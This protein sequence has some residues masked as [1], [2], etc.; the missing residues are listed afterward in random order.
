[1]INIWIFVFFILISTIGTFFLMKYLYMRNIENVTKTIR[2][3]VHRDNTLLNFQKDIECLLFLI[4]FKMNNSNKYIVD[5]MNITHE[6]AY[7]NEDLQNKLVEQI[8][9]D[10]V[11][12]LSSDYKSILMKY[13]NEIGLNEFITESVFVGISNSIIN[14][15]KTKIKKMYYAQAM[16]LK[17][18][19]K[20]ETKK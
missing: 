15:N 3:K 16:R 4:E 20:E 18:N 10:I 19:K 9:I 12:C 17:N 7:I 14:I 11:S 8:T 2:T 5:P 1:M 13:F 6:K